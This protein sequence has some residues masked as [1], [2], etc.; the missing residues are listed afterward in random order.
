MYLEPHAQARELLL[1]LDRRKKIHSRKEI[2]SGD[3]IVDWFFYNAISALNKKV[4]R[5]SLVRSLRERKGGRAFAGLCEYE[6]EK[7]KAHW[8]LKPLYWLSDF[9][10]SLQNRSDETQ[11]FI[12]AAKTMHS[13]RVELAETLFHEALHA[14]FEWWPEWV[15]EFLDSR[16]WNRLHCNQKLMVL[17]YVPRRVRN[18]NYYG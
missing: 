6:D 1:A 18:I 10:R 15:V 13:N 2:T 14:A 3:A 16:I 8:F 12:S 5:I 7:E 17:S 11:I 4:E 9:Y